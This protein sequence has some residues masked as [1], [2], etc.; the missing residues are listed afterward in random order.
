M[1]FNS[2]GKT[3]ETKSFF[4]ISSIEID[5]IVQWGNNV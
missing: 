2:K 4:M 5:Y 3:Y 1:A